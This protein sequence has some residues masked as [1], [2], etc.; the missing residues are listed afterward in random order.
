VVFFSSRRRH[1]RLVSDWSSD[2]CSSD[3]GLKHSPLIGAFW[4]SLDQTWS[5]RSVRTVRL[6]ASSAAANALPSGDQAMAVAGASNFTS[7]RSE[8]RRVGK[9]WRYGGVGSD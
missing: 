7:V 9:E 4:G 3:L 1:T 2:V 8:E 6:P 5:P